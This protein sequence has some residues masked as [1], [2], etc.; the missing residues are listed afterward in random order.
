MLIFFLR[1]VA[2]L[3]SMLYHARR[4][5]ARYPFLFNNRRGGGQFF[6]C[7]RKYISIAS[8]ISRCSMIRFY[9][10][11]YDSLSSGE[12]FGTLHGSSS[13]HLSTIY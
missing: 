11:L 6:T 13:E 10:S 5:V 9:G 8:S 7:R 3:R 12:R 2:N 4:F 1:T